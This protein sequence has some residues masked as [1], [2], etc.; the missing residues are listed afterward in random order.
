MMIAAED[1]QICKGVKVFEPLKYFKLNENKSD[2]KDSI[3]LYQP[4][5]SY[6]NA[7]SLNPSIETSSMY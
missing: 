6:I 1:S 2:V 7:K 4:I 5:Q 3:G